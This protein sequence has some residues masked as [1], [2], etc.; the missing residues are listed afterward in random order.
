MLGWHFTVK[1]MANQNLGTWEG[2]I[3]SDQWI[4]D[5]I[6]VNEGKPVELNGG[7][8]NIYTVQSQHIPV[9]KVEK[10]PGTD[11]VT[12]IVWDQS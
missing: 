11:W 7:Y 10:E 12:V 6:K 2:G 1:D 8:P 3:C 9:D 5:A 4:M